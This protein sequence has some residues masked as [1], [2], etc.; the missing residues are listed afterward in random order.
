MLTRAVL[1]AAAVACLVG[2]VGAVA[3]GG[4]RLGAWSDAHPG[5]ATLTWVLWNLV[6]VCLGGG[7]VVL[8]SRYRRSSRHPNPHRTA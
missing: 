4:E 2:S 5:L 1:V 7:L 8:W 3:I 6:L